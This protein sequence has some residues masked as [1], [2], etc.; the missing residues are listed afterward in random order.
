MISEGFENTAAENSEPF[1]S[2]T[3][4]VAQADPKIR[5]LE[6]QLLAAKDRLMQV[7]CMHA[8]CLIC[9]HLGV[10]GAGRSMASALIR[11]TMA[12]PRRYHGD[13]M[14]IPWQ[15]HGKRIGLRYRQVQVHAI[16]RTRSGSIHVCVFGGILP[17][18]G[19]W[20]PVSVPV[21]WRV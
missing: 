17:S 4:L 3:Q 20:K 5:R 1:P 16:S 12:I 7:W 21:I 8:S 14:A 13:T 6:T 18:L 19:L 10:W 11:D 9:D 2:L 15:Y